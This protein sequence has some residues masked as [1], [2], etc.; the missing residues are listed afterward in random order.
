MARNF[1]GCGKWE[2]KHWFIGS[3]PGK[4][5]H[6]DRELLSDPDKDNRSRYKETHLPTPEEVMYDPE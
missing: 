3:E 4:L 1:Y 2:A 5:K 6:S